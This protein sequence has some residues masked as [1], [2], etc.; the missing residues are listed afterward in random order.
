VKETDLGMVCTWPGIRGSTGSNGSGLMKP[1]VK[2]EI[3]VTR[4]TN[5]VMRLVNVQTFGPQC[6]ASKCPK[7]EFYLRRR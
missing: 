2:L 6:L 5:K 7:T 3:G 4:G 1:M